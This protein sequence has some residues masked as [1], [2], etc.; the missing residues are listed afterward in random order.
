MKRIV[1]SMGVISCLFMLSCGSAMKLTEAD[2]WL[3]SKTGSNPNPAVQISGSWQ[4]SVDPNWGMFQFDQK[5]G[6]V[7]G[8]IADYK[9]KGV[10]NGN[11]VYLVLYYGETVDYTVMLEMND[12]HELKGNYYASRDTD[13]LTP[14]PM[15]LQKNP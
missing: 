10:V 14:H 8:T 5:G 15:A 6:N 1:V 13:L 3:T 11:N 9:I 7:T 2:S 4:D 12:K